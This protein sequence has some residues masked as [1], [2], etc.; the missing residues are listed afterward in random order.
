MDSVILRC[1]DTDPKVRP[2][3]ALEVAAALGGERPPASRAC[4]GRDAVPRTRSPPP[5]EQVHCRC[6]PRGF[7]C[8]VSAWFSAACIA[9]AR[10]ST[11][12]GLSGWEKSPELLIDR[13]RD[14]I[15]A[16]GHPVT[17]R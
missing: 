12:V 16:A 6:A 11:V 17:L 10:Y 7:C 4:G 13:A 9:L 1:L 15:R 14:I 8:S 3:S 2:A 5:V